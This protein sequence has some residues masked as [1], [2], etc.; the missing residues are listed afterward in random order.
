MSPA[1]NRAASGGV[2]DIVT[3]RIELCGTDPAIWRQLEVPTSITLKALHDIIHAAMGWLDY[4]LWE[5]TREHAT[6]WAD[7]G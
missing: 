7:R 6:P 2:D 3:I 5:F 1:R 4:H